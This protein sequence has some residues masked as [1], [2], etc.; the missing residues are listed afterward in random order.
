LVAYILRISS[1]S[2][3]LEG[4]LFFSLAWAENGGG[5]IL[6]TTLRNLSFSII[7]WIYRRKGLKWLLFL[8]YEG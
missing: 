1:L 8:W 5:I 3:T 6:G 7:Y 4:H 2:E